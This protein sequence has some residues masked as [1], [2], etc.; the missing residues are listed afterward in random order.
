MGLTTARRTW[1][2]ER[3]GRTY[4]V[5]MED[6]YFLGRRVVRVNGDIVHTGRQLLSDHSGAY[7]F[8]LGGEPAFLKISTNGLRYY[9]ELVTQATLAV[10][11]AGREIAQQPPSIAGS[12]LLTLWAL[13]LAATIVWVADGR[14]W[15]EPAVAA[16]G[17][18]VDAVV[19]GAETTSR[20]ARRI[21]YRFEVGP[22]SFTHEGYIPEERYERARSSGLVPIRYLAAAPQV[23]S[24]DPDADEVIFDVLV[25][26]LLAACSVYF[27]KG[28]VQNVGAYQVWKRLSATG[29]ETMGRITGVGRI[30]DRFMTATGCSF[31]YSYADA[32]SGEHRGR[33]GTFTL[34]A[35]MRYPVG[36]PVR[37]RYDPDKPGDSIMLTPNRVQR[38]R[39]DRVALLRRR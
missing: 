13:A 7:Q 31:E 36:G 5:E 2:V 35:A 15:R 33:S 12:A 8:D 23:N 10:M 19:T 22:D 27:L 4:V 24:F 39:T 1:T 29:V 32:S 30:R 9:Y 17:V 11:P 37:I 28:A 26:L 34:D 21:A 25:G 16:G 6:E 38:P 14:L 20:G 18:R 3:N